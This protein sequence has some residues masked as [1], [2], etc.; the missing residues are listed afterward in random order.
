MRHRADELRAALAQHDA[1]TSDHSERVGLVAWALAVRMG[2]PSATCRRMRRAGSLHDVGKLSCPVCLLHKVGKLNDDEWALL[3]SHPYEGRARLN[4]LITDRLI[5]DAV[6]QHHERWD[7]SGYPDGRRGEEIAPAA[8]V[9]AVADVYD[10]L[11][12]DRPY[13]QAWP[14]EETVAYIQAGSGVLFDPVV[15]TAFLSVSESLAA[16][17]PERTPSQ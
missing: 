1:D 14:H 6:H 16:L 15:V 9:V 4:G 2:W 3:Q 7:G 10:A 8:R 12:S 17:Y 13:K 11:K 5:L